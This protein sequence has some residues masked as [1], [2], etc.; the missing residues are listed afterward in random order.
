MGNNLNQNTKVNVNDV[1]WRFA[2]H[3]A[4]D[5]KCFYSGDFISYSEMVLD[6]LIPKKYTDKPNNLTEL[7]KKY[8]L[9]EDF[10]LND[11]YNLVP[12]KKEYNDLKR[13]YLLPTTDMYLEKTRRKVNKV[14]DFYNSFLKGRN[15]EKNICKAKSVQ[16]KASESIEWVHDLLT[17]EQGEF[18]ISENFIDDLYF[19]SYYRSSKRIFL[20]GLLPSLFKEDFS[21]CIVL[22][23]LNLR[24]LMLTLASEDIAILAQEQHYNQTLEIKADER[25]FPYLR[26]H[27][28]FNYK[29]VNFWLP[30]S[31]AVEFYTILRSYYAKIQYCQDR[32]STIR[33]TK[34]F[35]AI[36]NGHDF[37]MGTITIR[38]WALIMRFAKEFDTDKGNSDW[39][40]F[41]AKTN[42]F[43][44]ISLRDNPFLDKCFHA[45]IGVE[46]CEHEQFYDNGSRSN[47]VL[48]IWH[49]MDPSIVND[50]ITNYSE[51]RVWNAEMV[52][53][54]V[55][56]EFIPY[57]VW[58]YEIKPLN[59]KKL[60]RKKISYEQFQP[61]F[62][63]EKYL[64]D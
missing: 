11:I 3:K 44:V 63:I 59:K 9:P 53:K 40:I 16:D 8:N 36:N 26:D 52:Y 29:M 19:P 38:L 45:T 4:Y 50:D 17:D 34:R 23:S 25:Q 22:K 49:K 14:S 42:M 60:R 13:D 37:I 55:T 24:S 1:A 35:K 6:N 56:K 28:L 33:G 18:I 61:N 21:C 62:L 58:Y 32:V 15:F 12:C 20:N 39:H 47:E 51:R 27:V 30:M 10:H 2:L 43:N 57:L 31:E 64:W 41:D 7:I 5:C 54:W 48:L 46:R